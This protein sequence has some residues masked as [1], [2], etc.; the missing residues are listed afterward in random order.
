MSLPRSSFRLRTVNCVTALTR[1]VYVQREER[2]N[3]PKR[4]RERE[5]EREKEKQR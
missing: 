5:S 2:G 1:T 3:P 4:E